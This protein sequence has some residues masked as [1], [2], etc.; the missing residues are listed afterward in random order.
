MSSIVGCLSCNFQLCV[1]SL[2]KARD[3]IESLRHILSSDFSPSCTP[4]YPCKFRLA[5]HQAISRITPFHHLKRG[6]F[7]LLSPVDEHVRKLRVEG[8]LIILSNK[9]S[10]RNIPPSR[11]SGGA[12]I[13]SDAL[14]LDLSSL[15]LCIGVR[16]VVVEDLCWR[17]RDLQ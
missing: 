3:L 16:E 5:Y 6:W 1:I 9:E 12:G 2:L 14:V 15:M 10:G 13:Y 4:Q 8:A 17:L 11:I 7:H